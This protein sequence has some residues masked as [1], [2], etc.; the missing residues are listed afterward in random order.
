VIIA[1]PSLRLLY[2]IDEVGRPEVTLKIIGHQWYWRYEYSDFRELA[3]DSYM[4]PAEDLRLGGY[5]LLEVDHRVCLPCH[6]STRLRIRSADVIHCWAVPS[7]GLKV[8]AIPGRINQV[9][10][11]PNVYGVFYGMC[12]EICGANHAFIPI[13]VEVVPSSVFSE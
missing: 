12:S 1:A 5:R 7:I 9:T 11:T 2:E 13:V 3:L 10:I 4:V 8:D 6:T